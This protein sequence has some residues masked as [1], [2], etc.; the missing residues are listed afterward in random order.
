MGRMIMP[1]RK[2]EEKRAKALRIQVTAEEFAKLKKAA[3]PGEFSA[4]ARAVLL[5][6]AEK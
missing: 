3:P 1:K 6:E 5:R 4:W 2:Q